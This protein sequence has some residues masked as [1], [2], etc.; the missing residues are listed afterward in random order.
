MENVGALALLVA[1]CLAVYSAVASLTG[2][3][4]TQTVPRCQRGTVR[5]CRLGFGDRRLPAFSSM[6]WSQVTF[7]W[8]TCTPQQPALPAVYKFAAWWGGQEGSLLLWAWCSPRTPPSWSPEPPQVPRHDAVRH[9]DADG[10][11]VFPDVDLL[12]REP[13]RGAG[14]WASSLHSGRRPGAES[15]AAV[16]DDGRSI[17]RC[18]ISAMSASSFRSRSRWHR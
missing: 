17:R 15:A 11:A 12:R 14:G 10:D 1:L 8:R 6:L 18:C 4:K 16:L 5:V 2:K 7:G 13:V 3:W 9:R